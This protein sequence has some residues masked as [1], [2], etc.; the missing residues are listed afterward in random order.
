MDYINLLSIFLFIFF[1]IKYAISAT[2]KTNEEVNL[3]SND[4]QS[5]LLKEISRPGIGFP[6]D[7]KIS[8]LLTLFQLR[9][10]IIASLYET[11]REYQ[12]N[13]YKVEWLR[14]FL[15]D[16]ASLTRKSYIEYSESEKLELKKL[17]ENLYRDKYSRLYP[18]YALHTKSSEIQ[19]IEIALLF[20]RNFPP[21]K[22]KIILVLL[23]KFEIFSEI[24]TELKNEYLLI[25]DLIGDGAFK[26]IFFDP[27]DNTLE[28]SPNLLN[29]NK[30]EIQQVRESLERISKI[31]LSILEIFKISVILRKNIDSKFNYEELLKE[32]QT[33]INMEKYLEVAI[34]Q[35]GKSSISLGG[36]LPDLKEEEYF[37]FKLNSNPL[38]QHYYGFECLKAHEFNSFNL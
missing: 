20:W 7:E 23:S 34:S 21:S 31:W 16:Y 15:G 33:L 10:C 11:I 36:Q 17:G 26:C 13:D 12:N 22:I 19:N 30:P 29:S 2:N 38:W 5:N 6:N 14:A 32:I 4:E 1:V 18:S 3:D 37:F 35:P 9:C 8:I 28:N 25:T 24:I 27:L